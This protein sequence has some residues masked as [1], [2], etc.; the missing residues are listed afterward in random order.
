MNRSKARA[1]AEA[2]FRPQPIRTRLADALAAR[3]AKT[4]EIDEN[5]ARLR[6]LRLRRDGEALSGAR[7][8]HRA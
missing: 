3:Q 2:L 8:A 7:P 1:A 6:I 5:T 4:H